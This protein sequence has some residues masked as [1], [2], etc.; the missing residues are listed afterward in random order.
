[1]LPGTCNSWTGSNVA[2]RK[3]EERGRTHISVPFSITV[4]G[5]LIMKKFKLGGVKK[6]KKMVTSAQWLSTSDVR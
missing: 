4:K 1:M 3:G 2:G 5:M 6:K